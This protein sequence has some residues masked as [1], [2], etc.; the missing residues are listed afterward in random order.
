MKWDTERASEQCRRKALQVQYRHRRRNE[1]TTIH[2]LDEFHSSVSPRLPVSPHLSCPRLTAERGCCGSSCRAINPARRSA[3]SDDRYSHSTAGTV[4][5]AAAAAAAAVSH[6]PRN[7]FP[8]VCP[9]PRLVQPSYRGISHRTPTCHRPKD[10]LRL[11]LIVYMV[12]VR[13]AGRQRSARR[14]RSQ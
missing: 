11:M 6:L 3:S 4:A 14:R 8:P 13:R 12:A 10:G 1:V 2:L 5:A 9:L 7:A